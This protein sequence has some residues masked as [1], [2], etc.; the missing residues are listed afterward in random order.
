[1]MWRLPGVL[2]PAEVAE[3]RRVLAG[4]DWADGLATAGGQSQ[5]AK[6]NLQLAEDSAEAAQLG[7][8]VMRALAASP[9]FV[10]A[11]LPRRVF[12]PLFNCYRGGMGF[13]DHIDNAVRVSIG[14]VRFRTD[15]S[16][17]LFLSDPETYSGGE[18]VIVDGFAEQ[19]V[20]LP[21]GDAILYPAGAVHRVEPVTSGERLAAFSWVQS[22][23]ADGSQRA[24]LHQ[25]D[26][27]IAAARADLGDAHPAAI[28]LV[29]AYHNLVRMWAEV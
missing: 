12:P 5:L 4:A 17:T 25:L 24:L 15:L 14:G 2:T 29:G 1:M 20:K 11:A 6:R 10:A 16:W 23:L 22:M 9:D 27:A 28:S 7:A 8:V 19:R 3:C 18:L 13:G 21:A 26:R